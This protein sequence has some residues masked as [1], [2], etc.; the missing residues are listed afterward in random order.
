MKGQKSG[1]IKYRLVKSRIAVEIKFDNIIMAGKTTGVDINGLGAV[2]NLIR[3]RS[4]S[5]VD[6]FNIVSKKSADEILKTLV[7]KNCRISFKSPKF[8][9]LDVFGILLRVEKSK[10]EKSHHFVAVKFRT[11]KWGLLKNDR[12]KLLQ[13]IEEQ[14]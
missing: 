5:T 8:D 4:L 9:F 13:Y 10:E 1:R 2:V 14:K 3:Y 12:L 11:G 7:G 6:G